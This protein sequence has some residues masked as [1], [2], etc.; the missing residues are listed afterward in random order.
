MGENRK[1]VKRQFQK[2]RLFV[3]VVQVL[4]Q[5][6]GHGEHVD[7]ILFEDG[8]HGIVTADL[9][10]IAR[11]LQVVVPDVLPDLLHRLRSRQLFEN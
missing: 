1:F 9:S 2:R 3:R 11:V 7:P 6:L 10:A 4:V 8:A 5:N